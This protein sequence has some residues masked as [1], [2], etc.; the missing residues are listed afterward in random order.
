MSDYFPKLL[1]NWGSRLRGLNRSKK[2]NLIL[3]SSVLIL[4]I[5]IFFFVFPG[6]NAFAKKNVEKQDKIIGDV[7]PLNKIG[8]GVEI[9][10]CQSKNETCKDDKEDKKVSFLNGKILDL[11]SGHPLEKMAS[12]ISLKNDEVASF[13]VAIAKKESDWGLHSPKK[14]GRDCFNYWG[15]R[16]TY[17]QTESGYSCFDSPEQAVD[18][19]GGRIEELL[20][21]GINTPEKMLVWKC[22][23]SCISHDPQGV[24][25]WVADVNMYLKKMN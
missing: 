1:Q 18:V 17:N 9:K 10:K 21:K 23:A 6:Q 7:D 2:K 14:N 25:K 16:G 13:L 4:G 8:K 3:G 11:V 5:G 20:N 12:R 15:Y 19:V 24:R 22:G